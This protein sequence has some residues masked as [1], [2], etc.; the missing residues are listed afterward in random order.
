V[1]NDGKFVPGVD[2]VVEGRAEGELIIFE[3]LAGTYSFDVLYS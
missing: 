1:W 3:V 2:G